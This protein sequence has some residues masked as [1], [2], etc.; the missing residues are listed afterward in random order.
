M[1]TGAALPML[2]SSLKGSKSG[3]SPRRASLGGE[4]TRRPIRKP[5]SAAVV[6]SSAAIAAAAGAGPLPRRHLDPRLFKSMSMEWA[7]Q[8][9]P[10]TVE[11]TLVQRGSGGAA[12]SGTSGGLVDRGV[13]FEDSTDSRSGN[14]SGD[15]GSADSDDGGGADSGDN[16]DGVDQ[17]V[18][19]LS[20]PSQALRLSS[21]NAPVAGS[22]NSLP[23][24]PATGHTRQ[25]RMMGGSI[26]K[27]N[28][29]SAT[30]AAIAAARHVRL[31]RGSP[32]GTMPVPMPRSLSSTSTNP[33]LVGAASPSTAAWERNRRAAAARVSRMLADADAAETAAAAIASQSQ[34][35]SR[36]A[37]AAEAAA[38]SVRAQAAA[39][40]AE[41]ATQNSAPPT[42]TK[43][44]DPPV[45]SAARWELDQRTASSLRGRPA[46]SSTLF[47]PPHQTQQQQRV[48]HSPGQAH[49]NTDPPQGKRRTRDDGL[50]S[51]NVPQV[52]PSG[53]GP[54]PS[55]RT[56]FEAG[57]PSFQ[58]AGH[59]GP[60]ATS[61]FSNDPPPSSQPFAFDAAAFSADAAAGKPRSAP[62]PTRSSD[63][64]SFS[65][66][67]SLLVAPNGSTPTAGADPSLWRSSSSQ[68]TSQPAS[69]F[70]ASSTQGSGAGS[71][72]GGFGGAHS[73][74]PPSGKGPGSGSGGAS[75]G[76]LVGGSFGG[77]GIGAR[78]GFVRDRLGGAPLHK[79]AGAQVG[80]GAG[81]SIFT[82][83]SGA[84]GGLKRSPSQL[85]LHG[86]GS[87]GGAPPAA[88]SLSGFG[89]GGRPFGGEVPPTSA[90]SQGG[91]GGAVGAGA[92]PS[93][94]AP[95]PLR[96]S[97]GLA[98]SAAPGAPPS[99][100]SSLAHFAPPTSVSRGAGPALGAAPTPFSFGLPSPRLQ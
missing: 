90:G 38:A 3:H 51:A 15:G 74:T 21:A 79:A 8:N 82:S 2:R 10:S 63:A 45:Q 17:S 55:R 6:S 34:A 60:H 30:L 40:E 78:V 18:V 41:L 81:A 26:Q 64:P 72:G 76:G 27:A 4:I 44:T 83:T 28:S 99:G 87:S 62:L 32:P 53:G 96:T 56:G 36:A 75:G 68:P 71:S 97:S 65:S 9:G 86:S 58:S 80:E 57:G 59:T 22:S 12:R 88:A 20:G 50:S 70:F 69:V 46:A 92:A 48:S 73:F 89:G 91:S 49:P 11:R 52:G 95:Q 98:T 19:P 25:R 37:V 29:S 5:S 39:E 31:L 67:P 35:H 42:T 61:S 24:R 77:N 43:Q 94:F 93:I 7:P 33:D 100:G 85:A 23:S 84:S 47:Q 14:G 1:D 16:S 66:T 54:G 13:L